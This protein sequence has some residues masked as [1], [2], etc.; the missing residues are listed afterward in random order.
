MEKSPKLARQ[1]W[2]IAE[3]RKTLI[4]RFPWAVTNTHQNYLLVDL[5]NHGSGSL[6]RSMQAHR[7]ICYDDTTHHY[8]TDLDY[9]SALDHIVNTYRNG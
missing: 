9:K 2:K 8:M 5:W 1:P 3:T 6:N 7:G 4:R